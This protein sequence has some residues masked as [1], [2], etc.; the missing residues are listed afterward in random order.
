MAGKIVVLPETLTHRIAAG[1]VVERPAS[2]V[3]ELMEN[4]LD[5]GA[6]EVSVALQQGGCLSV[7]VTDNGEGIER[8]DV[9]LAFARFATSKIG[10]FSDL[11]Q[12]RSYGFRGEALPSIASIARVE[13]VTRTASLAAGTRIVVEAGE[14][15]EIAE[16]GCQ[17]GTSV[18]VSS[19]FAPVPVRR[20]FL[21]SEATERS[22]CLEAVTRLALAKWGVKVRAFAEGR[23]VFFIP[24]APS[25]GERIALALGKEVREALVPVA[26]R[27]GQ[28]VLEGFASR[29]E[30]TRSDT[31]HLYLYVNGRFVRDTLLTQAVMAAYRRL[32][33]ARRY[34]TVVL[35]V[36][37]PAEEVDVNVHP[38]KME[39]RFRDPR[40]VYLLV[41]ETLGLALGATVRTA[42]AQQAK[43]LSPGLGDSTGPRNGE[44]GREKTPVTE[45]AEP[46]AAFCL[47]QAELQQTGR[48]AG[49]RYLGQALGTYLVFAGEEGLVIVDQHAAHERVLFERLK[50]Q[51][52]VRGDRPSQQLLIPEVVTLSPQ[53]MAFLAESTVILKEAGLEVEQFGSDAV[54]VKAIPAFL[55]A[56]ESRAMLV[57]LLEG[58]GEEGGLLDLTERREIIFTFLACRGAVKAGQALT[59]AEADALVRE[60]DAVPNAATCPHGRPVV[61]SF[62][63]ARLEQMF[64]RR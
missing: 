31:R 9:P 55:S 34:P 18:T 33:E 50:G 30:I 19:I 46:A 56:A 4:A 27:R 59:A 26:G 54:A 13:M 1:E 21:K 15:K 49:L 6:T 23:Q 25:L 62:S 58:L 53:E 39:V 5:A 11:Y 44:E 60:L 14:V 20:K 40:A 2:I 61:V 32:I 3:K 35:N 45:I 12:V 16:V 24:S 41:T 17:V 48:F 63:L 51:A 7:S 57:D 22:Y 10:T 37:L 8:A 29:P 47:R 36:E 64:K 28:V 38:A 42:P 52:A 43:A